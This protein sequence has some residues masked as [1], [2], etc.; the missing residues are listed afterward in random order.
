[1]KKLM[2]I[3]VVLLS[4]LTF[5]ISYTNQNRE[6]VSILGSFSNNQISKITDKKNYRI[7]IIDEPKQN[8]QKFLDELISLCQDNDYILATS[9]MINIDTSTHKEITYIYD[10]N[11]L[12]LDYLNKNYGYKIKLKSFDDG[13]ITTDLSDTKTNG[14]LKITS[15]SY[16]G[17]NIYEYTGFDNFIN[18]LESVNNDIIYNIYGND[19]EKLSKEINNIAQGLIEYEVLDDEMYEESMPVNLDIYIIIVFTV[20]ALLICIINEFLRMK[21]EI[22]VMKLMGYSKRNL[23]SNLFSQFVIKIIFIYL[24]VNVILWFIMVRNLSIRGLSFLGIIILN[25]L[26]FIIITVIITV[27]AYLL[28]VRNINIKKSLN[29]NGLLKISFAFKNVIII[30]LCLVLFYSLAGAKEIFNE[31]RLY[32]AKKNISDDYYLIE[33]M[34]NNKNAYK[35]IEILLKQ[36][37]TLACFFY[38]EANQET[39]LPYIIVNKNYLNLYSDEYKDI[40]TPALL[41]PEAYKD[42][43]IEQYKYGTDCKV[44][45]VKGHHTYLNVVNNMRGEISDPV[46]LLSDKD[47]YSWSH[48]LLRNDKEPTYYH[49]LVADY[50]NENEMRLT[51]AS[52]SLTIMFRYYT[53]PLLVKLIT[54]IGIYLIVYLT[55]IYMYMM[56]Y[57]YQNA[58]EISIKKTLGYSFFERYKDVYLINLAGYLLPF[59]INVFL[60]KINIFTT[61]A[62]ILFLIICEVCIESIMMKKFDHKTT[63]NLLK[64]SE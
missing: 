57:F 52:E 1:M 11:N 7:L 32:L 15:Q 64:G 61:L 28:L 12:L 33:N 54:Y 59:S 9:Q 44:Y 43:A 45:Y 22:T 50:I 24:F 26:I 35:A 31:T 25:C 20:I 56:L 23:F 34:V 29:Y 16:L 21:K 48:L 13:Y 55:T 53:L 17:N 10:Q 2:Y 27:C 19:L 30:L 18:K 8:N 63:V 3:L 49:N 58:K 6:D 41:V 42:E 39:E 40:Q 46:I 36:K 5:S 37:D 51:D 62:V 60:L 38:S 14:Y 47:Y 4:I